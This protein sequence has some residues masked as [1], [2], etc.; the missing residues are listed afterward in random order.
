MIAPV[1]AITSGAVVSAAVSVYLWMCYA[2]FGAGTHTRPAAPAVAPVQDIPLA[3]L[4]PG[5]RIDVLDMYAG[6]K[7]NAAMQKWEPAVVLGADDDQIFV[8]GGVACMCPRHLCH[9]CVYRRVLWR[10]V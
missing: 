5:A 9:V 10:R 3:S 7:T 8:R 1:G 2:D 4:V 6:E